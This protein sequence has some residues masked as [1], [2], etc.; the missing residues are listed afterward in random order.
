MHRGNRQRKLGKSGRTARPGRDLYPDPAL[1]GLA[2][3]EVKQQ[4]FAGRR[5][6]F[7]AAVLAGS[8][9]QMHVGRTLGKQLVHVAFAI[10]QHRRAGGLRPPPPPPPGA[11]RPA[12]RPPAPRPPPPPPPPP[13]RPPPGPP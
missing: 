8:H 2:V 1:L 10:A 3:D 11:T 9:H 7:D 4:T 5:C 6:R 13:A 12:P